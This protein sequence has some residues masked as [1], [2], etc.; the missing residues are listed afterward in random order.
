MVVADNSLL[1]A[2]YLIVPKIAENKKPHAIVEESIKSCMSQGCEAFLKLK[3]FPMSANTV[4]RKIEE[5]DED[6]ENQVIKKF[7]ILL[8]ST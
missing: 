3:E 1:N 6:I 2:S 5:M 8:N 7:I 4:K